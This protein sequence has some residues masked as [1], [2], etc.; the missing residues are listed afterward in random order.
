MVASPLEAE[1]I[2]VAFVRMAIWELCVKLK[3]QNA[4]KKIFNVSMG[5]SLEQLTIASVS[6]RNAMKEHTVKI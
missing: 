5:R 1:I 6:V 4:K 3:H 2:V